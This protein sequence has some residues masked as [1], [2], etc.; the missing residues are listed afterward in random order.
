M[1]DHETPRDRNGRKILD[2][3]I[4]LGVPVAMYDAGRVSDATAHP[5]GGESIVQQ[6]FK[7]EVDINTIVR[8]FGISGPTPFGVGSGVYGDFTGIT[9]LESAIEAVERAERGFLKLPP[10]VRE[11]FGNDPAR[12]VA[13]AQTVPESDFIAAVTP[14]ADPAPVGTV[15]VEQPPASGAQ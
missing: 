15:V 8:R 5:G 9:D 11:R 12:L 3:L 7:D 6:A 1:S 2:F 4:P 14:A 13:F 10:E